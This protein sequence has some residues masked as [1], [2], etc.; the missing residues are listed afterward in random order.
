MSKIAAH[1]NRFFF[2]MLV[3]TSAAIAPTRAADPKPTF[4]QILKSHFDTWTKDSSDGKLTPERINALVNSSRVRGDEAAAVAALHLYFRGQKTPAPV[5]EAA[6]L[7]VP[8]ASDTEVERRDQLKKPVNL[9]KAFTAF[10]HHLEKSDRTLFEREAP[11]REGM[12]QGRLGDC[13]VVAPLGM[14]VTHH[15]ARLKA[16]FDQQSEGGVCVISFPGEKPVKVPR[17]TDTQIV[18]GSIA[19]GQGLWLNVMEEAVAIDFRAHGSKKTSNV[20]M[21][22]ISSG[23]ATART[24]QLL[25]G[26]SAAMLHLQA[27]D[28]N[29]KEKAQTEAMKVL[30]AVHKDKIL[31]CFGTRGTDLPAGMASHHAYGIIDFD[32]KKQTVTIWN[33]WGNR[34]KPKG[35]PGLKHGYPTE[36][37]VFSMP[38]EDALKVFWGLAYQTNKPL[39]KK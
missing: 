19:N 39:P 2:A 13:F 21:D 26:H 14:M 29:E 16:M 37:G 7:A 6:L 15:P 11:R 23:G 36:G 17:L 5:D 35:E 33:P 30:Q 12:S 22:I 24:I 8:N 9:E 20:A 18:L 28:T 27:T 32:A 31:A 4:A 3:V 25:T 34:Y 38:V 10:R 1:L